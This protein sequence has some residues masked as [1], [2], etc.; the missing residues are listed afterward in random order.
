[1]FFKSLNSA[2]ALLA[3]VSV[4]LG[5]VWIESRLGLVFFPKMKVSVRHQKPIISARHQKLG[6]IY[7]PSYNVVNV[8]LLIYIIYLIIINLTRNIHI[9]FKTCLLVE[10][11]NIIKH[12]FDLKISRNINYVVRYITLR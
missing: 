1:M 5:L 8:G 3:R 9:R 11:L 4:R 2:R 6:I 12:Y 7:I 10:Y